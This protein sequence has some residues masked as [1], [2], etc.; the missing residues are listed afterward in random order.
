MQETTEQYIKRILSHIEGKD[1][2]K[3]Q[4]AAPR[5]F[6]RLIRS[7]PKNRL[8]RKP[9]PGKWS[10]GEILAHL[11]ECELVAGYRIRKILEEDGTPI[12][13]FNQDKWAEAGHYARRDPKESLEV[14]AT[15]RKANLA[16]LRS[17]DPAQ[18][19]HYGM[20]SERGEESVEKVV[21]MFAGHD[22]NHLGQV[23][24]ILGRKA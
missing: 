17:L 16:L 15:L 4:A 7:V 23:E 3:S 10:V 2:M 6:E 18:W 21:R 9:A 8:M 13:A 24:R 20:H 5:K 12:Q 1:A 11:A 19:K 14:Y 22:L